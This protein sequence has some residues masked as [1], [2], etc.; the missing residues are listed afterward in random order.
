MGGAKEFVTMLD[1]VFIMPPIFDASYYGGVI[2]EI[3]EMQVMNS[4]NRVP[5]QTTRQKI[6]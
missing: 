4:S 1:S 3:R 2:H 6:W 5:I